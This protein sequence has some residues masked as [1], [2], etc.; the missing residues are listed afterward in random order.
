M[1][2]LGLFF[3]HLTPW[4]LE[5]K[6]FPVPRVLNL[7]AYQCCLHSWKLSGKSNEGFKSCGAKIAIFGYFGQFW[8]IFDTFWPPG[9]QTRIFPVPSVLKVC[10]YQCCLYFW[11]FSEKYNEELKSCGAKTAIFGYFGSFWGIFD[12][13][14]PPGERTRIFLK[15]PRMLGPF[16]YECAASCKISEKSNEWFLR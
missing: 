2:I 10:L 16:L 11:E 9:E 3:T 7:C 5:T 6:N 13:F 14:W 8:G 1:V 4:G 12:T 15:N